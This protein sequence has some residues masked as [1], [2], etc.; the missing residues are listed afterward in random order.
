[1][2]RYGVLQPEALAAADAAAVG[3]AGTPPDLMAG[4]IPS[5]LKVGY[6]QGGLCLCLCLCLPF[7]S[8]TETEI[9]IKKM[10]GTERNELW[11]EWLERYEKPICGLLSTRWPPAVFPMLLD[12]VSDP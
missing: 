7:R 8:L 4:G 5:E 10:K 12:S 1:M 11:R 6:R 9:E 3:V 2:V